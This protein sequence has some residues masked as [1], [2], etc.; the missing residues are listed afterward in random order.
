MKLRVEIRNYKLFESIHI[1]KQ[2]TVSIK[3]DMCLVNFKNII[4]KFRLTISREHSHNIEG[5]QTLLDGW[6]LIQW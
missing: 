3:Y 1:S 5:M 2:R 4:L 6:Q